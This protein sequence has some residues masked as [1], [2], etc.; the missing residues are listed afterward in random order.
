MDELDQKYSDRLFWMIQTV[1]GVVLGGG[2]TLH[3]ECLIHPFT[4]ANYVASFALLLVYGTTVW[5]WIDFSY[6]SVLNPYRPHDTY[7]RVRILSDLFIVILYAVLWFSVSDVI[8]KPENSLS[9][10]L[11]GFL[12]VFIL[13]FLSGVLRIK[14][15]GPKAS[16]LKLIA[17]FCLV[18]LTLWFGY[19]AL[20]NT[21]GPKS[22]LNLITLGVTAALMVLYRTLR[23]KEASKSKL[24]GIDVD[25]VLA[26][27]VSPLLPIIQAEHG[28]SL[29]YSEVTQWDLPIQNTNIAKLI[30]SKHSD[31][32]YV[33]SLPVHH[34]ASAVVKA[35]FKRHRIVIIT[36]RAEASD[37]WTRAWL[38]ANK[39]P[40]D[41]YIN[42]REKHNTNRKLAVLID[43]YLKNV[44]QF[45]RNTDGK[46]I[47][48][49]QPWNK[50][51]SELQSFIDEGR[52]FVA[53]DWTEVQCQLAILLGDEN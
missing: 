31:E 36:S 24:I 6:T 50:A 43:D 2:L 20:Y 4:A 25:G 21:G 15:H 13:Y 46:V 22:T 41:E 27:Q 38:K 8:G 19:N 9:V 32:D 7:E 34:G 45:L 3:R 16:R 40:F 35:L 49:N 12:V 52:L 47:L 1:F 44:S 42:T 37:N 10:L 39:I 48:F 14:Q 33:R 29:T 23:R 5:S 53:E 28:I 26:D 18:Y 17:T 11:F 51:R 30:E